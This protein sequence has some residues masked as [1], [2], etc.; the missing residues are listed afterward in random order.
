MDVLFPKQVSAFGKEKKSASVALKKK[1]PDLFVKQKMRVA[2]SNPSDNFSCFPIKHSTKIWFKARRAFVT[3]CLN[4]NP[5]QQ[6]QKFPSS[7][8]F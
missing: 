1:L 6:C 2:G 3:K 7:L 5:W 4:P 8:P